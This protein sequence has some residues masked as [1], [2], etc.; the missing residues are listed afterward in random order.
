MSWRSLPGSVVLL[1][2]PS[3]AGINSGSGIS[4]STGWHNSVKARMYLQAAKAENCDEAD[5]DRRIL[6]F[7]KN[8]YGPV[9]ESLTL[10][11]RD[12]LFLPEVGASAHEKAAKEA[13]A[14]AI[15]L[16]VLGKL[17]AQGR[18]ASPQPSASNYAPAT[19]AAHPDGKPHGRKGDY[20]KAMERLFEAGR[21]HVEKV[22][23]PSRNTRIIALG[24][25]PSGA[26][27]G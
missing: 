16:E 25:A 1:A 4:G 26:A 14:D 5:R 8:N 20:E 24:P 27:A 17:I 7:K 15:F 6:E 18:I 19:I 3:L 10:K 12:G 13:K 22:G 2:H 21:I 11:F 9:A 23:P